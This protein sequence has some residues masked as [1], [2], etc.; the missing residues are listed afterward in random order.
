MRAA[1]LKGETLPPIDDLLVRAGGGR[2]ERF[3]GRSIEKLKSLGFSMEELY[4]FVAPRRT[5]ARRIQKNEALSLKE[6]D[7][8]LRIMRVSANRVG[9]SKASFPSIC[10]SRKRVRTLSKKNFIASIME[11]TPECIS[12]AFP[13]MQIFPAA[14]GFWRR[15]DGIIKVIQWSI[16]R[17]TPRPPCWKS[18]FISSRRTCRTATNC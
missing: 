16:V 7:G 15:G 11:S 9:L 13:I 18:L 1:A 4:R 2:F 10:W 6:N 8:A 14:V 3:D 5:L 17:I 12:G